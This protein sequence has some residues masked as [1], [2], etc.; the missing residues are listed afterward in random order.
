[1]LCIGLDLINKQSKDYKNLIDITKDY[2]DFY[3]L[4]PAFF[5][6]PNIILEIA[7]YLNYLKLQWIYDGKIGD[8]L[9]TNKQ[10]ANYIYHVLNA[11]GVTLN[12]FVGFDALAPFIEHEDKYNFILCRTSNSG[13]K[14]I[15]DFAWKQ[16]SNFAHMSNSGLVV[17]GNSVPFLKQIREFNPKSLILSPGIGAQGGAIEETIQN[18]IYSVSRSIINSEDPGSAAMKYRQNIHGH[19]G[20]YQ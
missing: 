11:S 15:Q 14:L 10:Y 9:H 19:A 5:N 2:C 13:S 17:A 6:D 20:D 3:K 4:N 12:P 7:E 16:I 8:V 18:V 1:M